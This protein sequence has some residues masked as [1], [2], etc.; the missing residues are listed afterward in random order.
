MKKKVSIVTLAVLLPMAALALIV[1]TSASGSGDKSG[2]ASTAVTYPIPNTEKNS[3]V[4]KVYFTTDISPAGLQ[5]VYKALR[6]T[7]ASG[8]HVG[9]KVSTGEP[10]SSNYLRQDLIGNFVRSVLAQGSGG[11]YIECNTAYGGQRASVAAHYQ[12]AKVHGFEPIV[13]M[14]D[15]G[16]MSIP[17][18]GGNRLKQNYVGKHFPNYDFHVVLS[19]FKGHSMAGF[20]G[21]LKNMSIGYGSGKSGKNLI[22]SG[23]TGKSWTRQQD[24]FL[25][26][27]SEAAK[28]IVDYAGADNYVYLNVLN[29]MSVDCDCD[30]TPAAPTCADIGIAASLDP[31]ALD[32][33]CL[34][35]VWA[36]KDTGDLQARVKRQNGALT[37]YHAAEIGL[38]S[39]EYDLVSLD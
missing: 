31:V 34:D 22:H 21:A 38:G 33:A 39:L 26:A 20:G 37:V 18:T 25:E 3:S 17:V 32:K 36:A 5:A 29:H 12:V 27:M 23:G 1:C 4:V 9:I 30:G 16:E 2:T 10:P 6:R 14:D 13:L 7:P 8:D 19:H 24:T 28:S 15:E 11:E 35:L